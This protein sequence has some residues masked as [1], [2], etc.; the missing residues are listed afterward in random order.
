MSQVVS[1][2]LSPGLGVPEVCHQYLLIRVTGGVVARQEQATFLN[3]GGCHDV[4]DECIRPS[5]P[6]VT[7]TRLLAAGGQAQVQ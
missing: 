5:A 6:R 2:S 7:V 4:S 3:E 1:E